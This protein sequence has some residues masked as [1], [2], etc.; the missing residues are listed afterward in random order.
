[1]KIRVSTA[2]QLGLFVV[3]MAYSLYMAAQLPDTVP[4][5][6]GL[7][8]QPDSYG[9][10]WMDLLLM[11]GVILLMAALT[12]ALAK[13]SPSQ[14]QVGAFEETYGYVAFLVGALM[15][16]IHVVIVQ[17]SIGRHLD[18]T[19]LMMFVMFAFFALI[20]NVMGK[21]KRN[22]FMGI[23]TPW[24]LADERVWIATHRYGGRLWLVGGVIGA[25]AALI[26]V[27]FAILIALLLVMAFLP[28]LKS[29]QL[30]Q[31]LTPSP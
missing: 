16:A 25:I 9:S 8:G 1:M 11:P 27:P 24:T 10:K 31:K 6:W 30:Y 21:I 3:A 15:F 29:Y 5:H 18:M 17:A 13:I 4:T 28:I 19:R 2:A 14:F 23:R 20:G 7:N 26:G 22:F 12:P